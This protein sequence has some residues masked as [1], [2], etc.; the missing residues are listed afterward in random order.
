MFTQFFGSYLLHKQL[1]TSEQLSEALL[2]QKNTRLK[3]GVLA[4]N[5]GYMTA[6]QVE[7]AHARQQREDKRI[8]EVMVEMG[9][10]TTDQVEELFK[11]QPS[12]HL[13]LGQA[14]VDKGYMSNAQ[15]ENALNSYK[16]ENSLSD[17]DM[18]DSNESSIAK[19]ISSFYDLKAS[20]DRDQLTNY[21]SLIFKN[22]IRFIGDDFTPMDPFS[23]KEPISN[24]VL[25]NISGSENMTTL[26]YAEKPALIAFASRFAKEELE[27]DDE[28]TQA[29]VSEFINLHN[30]LF[31]VNVSNDTGAELQLE[32]QCYYDSMDI[33]G[34]SKACVVP[35]SYPFGIVN[36][37]IAM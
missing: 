33:K 12:G 32:P 26:I 10:L 14:L 25:Q 29:C 1:V 20:E 4:I 36:F 34:L 13:L 27:N 9:F 15:F 18:N 16:E 7:K 23:L 5:A 30:G 3:L 37:V 24:V 2:L 19:M 35:V 11:T 31:A 8:G 28:Y 6:D 17:A 22:L 21:V